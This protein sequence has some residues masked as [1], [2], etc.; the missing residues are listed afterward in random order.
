MARITASAKQE[1]RQRL[2][3]AAAQHFADHGLDGANV[4]A[5][6]LDAGFAKGTLYNYFQSKEQLFAE[7]L[8][9]A[10]RRALE[11]YAAAESLGSVRERLC[12]LAAADVEVL[13]HQEGFQK[14]LIRE[15][16]SFR[17][18]TYP[19]LAEHLNPF[20]TKVEQIL[21][22]GVGTGEVRENQ[23]TDQLALMFV[24]ILTLL[25]V[26]HWGSEGV[27]PDLGDIPDLAV[28]SFLDGAGRTPQPASE[29]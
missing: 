22:D 1:A 28:S 9:E 15:A 25:Y 11:I 24:G 6:S 7:V 17:K 18:K 5:I 3:E 13:R 16:M 14:V 12:S 23:P 29:R 2:L 4:D 10:C 21:A 8:A 27:W 19:L 20:L 26:H